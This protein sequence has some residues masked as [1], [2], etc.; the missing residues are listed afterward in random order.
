MEEGSSEESGPEEGDLKEEKG[1]CIQK[2][3][4][5]SDE[6]EELLK[7]IYDTLNLEEEKSRIY[8]SMKN[9]IF[10]VNAALKDTILHEWKELELER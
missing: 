2:F 3:L 1:S 4:F 6:T 5:P 9:Y 10:P 8:Q 7:L